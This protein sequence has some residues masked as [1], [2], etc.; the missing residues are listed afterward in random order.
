V[1]DDHF[2]LGVL[3]GTRDMT[4]AQVIGGRDDF[5]IRTGQFFRPLG[6]RQRGDDVTGK[7]GRMPLIPAGPSLAINF[8]FISVGRA[9]SLA[10]KLPRVGWNGVFLPN[11]LKS[12]DVS[13]AIPDHLG[14]SNFEIFSRF[15]ERIIL[16]GATVSMLGNDY[17]IQK[18]TTC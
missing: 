15:R 2:G 13:S 9:A 17:S 1:S 7:D 11:I 4:S 18:D 12:W 6:K 3:P 16:N 5:G 10:R 14:N 8:C